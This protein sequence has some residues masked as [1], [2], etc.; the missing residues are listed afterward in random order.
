MYAPVLLDVNSC[1]SACRSQ[2][3][4]NFRLPLNPPWPW[5]RIHASGCENINL[6]AALKLIEHMTRSVG[7]RV[8]LGLLVQTRHS[9]IYISPLAGMP[10]SPIHTAVPG[11]RRV[12]CWHKQAVKVGKLRKSEMLMPIDTGAVPIAALRGSFRNLI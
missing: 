8:I 12:R 4:L 3:D 11:S 5:Y 2:G 6:Q 7:L 9:S 10:G 1:Q